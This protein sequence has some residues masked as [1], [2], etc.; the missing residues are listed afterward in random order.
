V[1]TIPYS[2]MESESGAESESGMV[3]EWGHNRISFPTIINVL[4]GTRIE[5]EPVKTVYY[6]NKEK[7]MRKCATRK[8]GLDEKS[9]EEEVMLDDLAGAGFEYAFGIDEGYKWKD[10]W[11]SEENIIPR[12]VKIRVEFKSENNEKTKAFE[13][14]IF[15]PMGELG[16]EE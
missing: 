14:L 8:E 16:K 9:A 15:I 1:N 2:D 7:L 12:G 4:S 6:F 13:K 11:D 10:E 5:K 3:P